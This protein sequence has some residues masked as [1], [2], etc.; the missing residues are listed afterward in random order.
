MRASASSTPSN[1]PIAR[2]ELRAHARV[3]ADGAHR[4]D[5]HARVRRRQRDAA[6]R[7]E[8]F[9]QHPPALAEHRLPADHP[10]HRDEHVAARVRAV[11]EH[12]IERHVAAADLH[13]GVRGRNERARD[14]EVLLVAEQLVRVVHAEREAEQR[15]HRAQRDVALVPRHRQ[16]EHAL[17][18]VLAPADVRVVGNRGRVGAR[19]RIGQREARDLEA[20]GEARQVVALLLL[21]SVVQQQFAGTERVRHH[22]RH[23]GR[24]RA[25]RQLGDHLRMRV[26]GEAEAAVLLAG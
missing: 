19:V 22:H 2:L 11:L 10:V 6:A 20:L 1:L 12:R 4:E 23:R 25:R 18:L 3:A 17:A 8:A 5:R 26:R 9:H 15:G 13:A 21:G 7:R 16:A 24:A 14:A